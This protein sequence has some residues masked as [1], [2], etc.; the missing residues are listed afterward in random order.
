M[1]R[2]ATTLSMLLIVAL[3]GCAPGRGDVSGVVKYKSKP[4]SGGTIS[5]FDEARG[6]WS[7]PIDEE[8]R[9]A[10]TGV[11]SGTAKIAVMATIPISLPGAP[12]P[13]ASTQIPGRY[14]DHEKS[15]LTC[16]VRSGSQTHIVELE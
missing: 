4:I 9:Y 14:A 10:V 1:R 15:G 5:F 7:S 12:P 2:G 6:V 8:G 16:V 13:K 11:P 3:A